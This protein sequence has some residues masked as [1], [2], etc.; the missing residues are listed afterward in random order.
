MHRLYLLLGDVRRKVDRSGGKLKRIALIGH[1][2]QGEAH[3]YRPANA[4]ERW[5][6]PPWYHQFYAAR[7]QQPQQQVVPPA[8]EP[9]PTSAAPETV[10]KQPESEPVASAP[11]Q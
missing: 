9:A 8:P 7:Q 4:N 2:E 10:P 3:V 11:P 6:I 5:T 1:P